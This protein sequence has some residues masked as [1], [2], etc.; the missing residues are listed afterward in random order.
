MN[1]N[2]HLTKTFEQRK[3]Y[4]CYKTLLNYIYVE[5]WLRL[6]AACLAAAADNEGL[7]ISTIVESTSL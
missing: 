2:K 5:L 6:W 3:K 1:F 7:S 4:L